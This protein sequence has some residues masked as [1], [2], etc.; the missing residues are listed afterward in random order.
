MLE[1]Q[2]CFRSLNL[3]KPWTL[4][5]YESIGGYQQWRKILQEK[6]PPEKIIDDLKKSALRGRG[7]AGFPTGLKWSFIAR[8]TPG[9]KYVICNSDEGEPGTCKDR[10]ILR[11]NPHQVLEGL[12]IACY[13]MGASVA[14]N[15]IRGEFWEPWQRCEA[16]LEEAR[17]AGLLGKNILSSGIDVEIFNTQGAGAYICGEETALMESLEG[18]KGFPRFKPP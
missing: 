18:K 6:T 9:Q 11:F 3:E 13:T 7:G 10:E 5:T 4:K 1:N 12:A 8:N 14:Y 15:Y 16:A 2:V 17:Q